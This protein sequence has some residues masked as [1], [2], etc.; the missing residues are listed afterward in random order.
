[1]ARES[2]A[3]LKVALLVSLDD[4]EVAKDSLAG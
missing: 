1:M 4:W 3:S 2:L